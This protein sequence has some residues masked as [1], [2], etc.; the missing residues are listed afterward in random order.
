MKKI[1][2][3]TLLAASS[4]T[5]YAANFTSENYAIAGFHNVNN[6]IDALIVSYEKYVNKYISTMKKAKEGDETAMLEYLKLLQQAEELEKKIDAAKDEM[7]TT[8]L[9]K[10][11]KINLKLIKAM[12]KM[13]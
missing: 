3:V 2:F 6:D 12:E 13:K 7:T 4:I 9:E 1:L 11:N 10:F 8:Q 5:S